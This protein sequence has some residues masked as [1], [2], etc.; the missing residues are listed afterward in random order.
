MDT[1]TKTTSIKTIDLHD[2]K[3]WANAWQT[4]NP[5][6][7]KAFLI[8]TEDLIAAL[9]EMGIIEDNQVVDSQIPKTGV[10]TYMAID[11]DKGTDKSNG[12][13]EKLLIVGTY[14]DEKGIHRDIIKN[15]SIQKSEVPTPTGT[16]VFDFTDPCP[17]TCDPNSPLYDPKIK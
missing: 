9:E 5:N 1:K 7:C 6:K 8:P 12:Y 2:A 3:K 11:K 14:I 17:N 4:E 15:E 16:G 13:G 10:R